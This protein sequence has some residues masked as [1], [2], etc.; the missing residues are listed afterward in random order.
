LIDSNPNHKG[1][2]NIYSTDRHVR[3]MGKMCRHTLHRTFCLNWTLPEVRLSCLLEANQT[4]E[5]MHHHRAIESVANKTTIFRLIGIFIIVF[6]A[7]TLI[8]SDKAASKGWNKVSET[9]KIMNILSGERGKFECGAKCAHKIIGEYSV[10]LTTGTKRLVVTASGD[11]ASDCHACAPQLS[12]FAFE[13]NNQKWRATWSHIA[14][15]K[16]GSWDAISGK[17]IMVQAIAPN[18]YGIFLETGY[19]GQG[20]SSSHLEVFYPPKSRLKKILVVCTAADSAGAFE[21]TDKHYFEWVA[22]Y[23]VASPDGEFADIE[24]N[25]IDKVTGERFL[26]HFT[27]DDIRYRS[28][29]T[30]IRMVGDGCGTDDDY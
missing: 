4:G 8:Q 9:R 1:K 28:R 29:D 14:A 13:E 15:L 16:R 3:L 22:S 7:S 11:P 5:N 25:M 21:K 20:Y 17:Q 2:V 26:S 30:D 12:F 6:A 27:F 24:F 10:G 23:K 18:Y 19:T